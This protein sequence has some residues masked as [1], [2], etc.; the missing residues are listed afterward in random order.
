MITSSDKTETFWFLEF[1]LTNQPSHLASQIPCLL[2][3]M[4]VHC[5]VHKIPPLVPILR[6][7]NPVCSFPPS[8]PWTH[9]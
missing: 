1:V 7:M 8:F 3:S 6:Q 4:K 5:P 9:S 2:W